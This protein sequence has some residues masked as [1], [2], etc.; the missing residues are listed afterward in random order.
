MIRV[1]RYRR[2]RREA[3]KAMGEKVDEPAA[4]VVKGKKGAAKNAE[5]V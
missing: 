1:P 5:P 2:K 4:P 3:L